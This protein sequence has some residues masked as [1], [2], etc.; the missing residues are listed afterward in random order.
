MDK[1]NVNFEKVLD[2][3]KGVFG[4][5]VV[6]F[7]LPIGEAENFKGLVSVI[8][9]VAY[10]YNGKD[11]KE[12]DIPEE[13][14]G[15]I[16]SINEALMEKVA[17]TTEELMEKYFEGEAFTI[18]EIRQGLKLSVMNGDLVP[19]IVGSA[20]EAM[21]VDFLLNVAKN[22]M[23]NPTEVGDNK[24]Y[25]GEEE[26]IRKVDVNEPFSAIVFKTIVDPFV[27]K[28]SL[29][30]VKSGK[31]TKDSEIYNVSKDKTE[32]LGGLFVLR[33]KN[34]IE[35]SEVVAGDIGATSKLSVTQTGDSIC[36]KSDP[37]LY[38]R[39][40]YPQPTL[41]LAVEPKSRD[42]EEKIGTSLQR[43]TED[44]PL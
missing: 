5:K 21:G 35:V 12:V 33:G 19:L 14:K 44:Q 16:E 2:Q 36:S 42:D 32:K 4:D 26:V 8:D 7:A 1:E 22:Y 43:L 15:E 27:G 31:I 37:T 17:E 20:E 23:P 40:E 30:K 3:I 39:I 6:P 38:D 25:K 10:E 18:E 24:G 41:F 34:Q 11:A 29:F 28:L 13:L 9:E